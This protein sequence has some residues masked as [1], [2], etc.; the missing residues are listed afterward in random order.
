MTP[1]QF[2]NRYIESLPVVPDD[3]RDELGL[4][5]FASLDTVTA[6]RLNL[7]HDVADFVTTAG[8]PESA[9]PWLSFD[10]NV[11]GRIA[12]VDTFPHMI[13][14][15]SNSSGD[16]VC[17]DVNDNYSLVYL[18]HDDLFRRI[19][20]N[21]SVS[22]FAECLCLYLGRRHRND[23]IDLLN[24]IGKIDPKATE[25]GTFWYTESLALENGG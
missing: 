18:N 17:L 7:P 24:A 16:D 4:E 23:P 13:A 5:R 21:S 1:I 22:L 20:I 10:F 2:K 11:D 14:I 9:S 12:P 25:I 8:L 19:F 3:L 6:N 15:G